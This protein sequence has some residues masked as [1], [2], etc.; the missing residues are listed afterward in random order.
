MGRCVIVG[1]ADINK[2]A[3]ICEK[4]CAD[5]YVIFCDSGLKHLENLQ[6]QPSLIVGDFDSHKNPH[7]D[8]ETIVLPCE[9]DDTSPVWCWRKKIPS[10]LEC[11][12]DGICGTLKSIVRCC[13]PHFFSAAS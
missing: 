13:I 8:I 1:D 11:G 2:Y 3:F 9:K 5:D 6:V 10:P 12:A 7:L 4:L